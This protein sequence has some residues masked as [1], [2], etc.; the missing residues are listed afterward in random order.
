[1]KGFT[2]IKKI[3]LKKWENPEKTEAKKYKKHEN[4]LKIANLIKMCF[5]R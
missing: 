3:Y 5:V 4:L 1:M 2:S